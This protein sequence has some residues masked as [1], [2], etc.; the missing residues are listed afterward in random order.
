METIPIVIY[1][2]DIRI[3]CYLF[4]TMETMPIVIYVKVK[5]PIA[6]YDND[7]HIYCYQI[8]CSSIPIVAYDNGKY[9]SNHKS[10]VSLGRPAL[11]HIMGN[12]SPTKSKIAKVNIKN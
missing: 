3:P 11:S 2:N 5:I 4:T 7:K 8:Q 6:I 1:D 9:T 12:K 10:F